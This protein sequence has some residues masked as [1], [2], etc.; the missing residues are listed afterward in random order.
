VL[1][2]K[3]GGMEERAFLDSVREGAALPEYDLFIDYI[4]MVVQL[5]YV[6]LWSTIWPLAGG[7]LPTLVFLF[8]L[9]H[10]TH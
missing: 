7:E 1:S 6:V 5:G 10:L 4:E 2:L 3:K 9:H 8:N